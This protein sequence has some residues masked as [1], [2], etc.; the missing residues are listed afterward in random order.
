M[1][2][3]HTS[4]KNTPVSFSDSGT[5]TPLVFLHGYLENSKMWSFFEPELV[6]KYRVICIDLLGH[7]QTGC[8]GYVHTMEDMADAVYAVLQELHI[9]KAIF[10]GHSMGGY[11]ALALSELYPE[12]IQGL[13]LVNSTSWADSLDRKKNRDRA[14]VAVKKDFTVFIRMSIANLFS[15]ENRVR[16]DARIELV[17]NEALQ[18]PL[19]GI[20]AA[21]EGMKMRKDREMQL[22]FSPFPKLLVLGKKDPVLNYQETISQIENTEVSLITFEDGHMSP[23]ENEHELLAVFFDF[24]KKC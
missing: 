7:G 10:I 8:L 9:R 24:F 12:I 2:F 16:L 18:T 5:G 14:I 4:Y 20:V 3:K 11:V 23:I 17:K 21:L 6:Q 15:E 13:A 22:H 19:Q 1:N